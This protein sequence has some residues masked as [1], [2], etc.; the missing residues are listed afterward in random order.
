MKVKHSGP[1]LF[2]RKYSK[3]T[4][5]IQKK[6]PNSRMPRIFIDLVEKSAF[7]I[8]LCFHI[9]FS[10]TEVNGQSLLGATHSEAVKAMRETGNSIHLIVCDG[11]NSASSSQ[12]S[13]IQNGQSELDSAVDQTDEQPPR[14]NSAQEVSYI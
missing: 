5:F 8:Y 7:Y 11:W 14:P 2:V 4:K 12:N 3:L 13:N 6:Y 9:I 1:C 10:F